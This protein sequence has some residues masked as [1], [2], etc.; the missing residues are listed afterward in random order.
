MSSLQRITT[1]YRET[2]DRI[3]LA[4]EARGSEGARSG[5]AVALWLTQ[6]LLN[7]LIPHLCQWLEQREPALP[8]GEVLQ[9]FAQQVATA[10]LEPQPAVQ[11]SAQHAEILVHSVDVKR[12]SNRITLVF[13]GADGAAVAELSTGSVSLR[14]WLHI[15]SAQYRKAQWPLT[16]WPAWLR[17]TH[18]PAREAAVLH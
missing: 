12:S 17:E 13:R 6:R 8:R 3:R 16:T 18:S 1:E 2:E 10:A 7:R 14:Q 9:T 15:L 4:G 11:V 5:P